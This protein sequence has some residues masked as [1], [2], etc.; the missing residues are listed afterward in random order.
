MSTGAQETVECSSC[1]ADVP[2]DDAS[3]LT[4]KRSK[5]VWRYLCPDCLADLSVPKGYT[6]KRD[7]SFLRGGAANEEHAVEPDETGETSEAMDRSGS[8]VIADFMGEVVTR[9]TPGASMTR[10]RVLLDRRRLILASADRKTA[11]PLSAIRDVT[12]G[13]DAGPDPETGAAIATVTYRTE[14]GEDVAFVSADPETLGKFEDVLFKALLHGRA[15][16]V[17]HPASVAGEPENPPIRTGVVD[18]QSGTLTISGLDSPV[19]VEPDRVSGISTGGREWAEPGATVLS[20]THRGDDAAVVSEFAV[21][22]GRL[23]NLLA[24]FVQ[25]DG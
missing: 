8:A 21:T 3:M 12:I 4:A 15:V 18:I 16:Q 13:G 23:A 6:V 25:A 19:E 24:R 5:A 2:I 14:S 22:T 10:G 9:E 1:G 11:I 17:K 20:V 7:L